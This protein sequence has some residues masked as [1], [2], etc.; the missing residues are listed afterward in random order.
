[1]QADSAAVAATIH[2]IRTVIEGVVEAQG[3]IA[4]AVTEQ[5]AASEEAQRAITGAA[6][7]ADQMARD[8]RGVAA[9]A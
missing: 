8:L 6:D 4:S 3:T 9:L 1:V 7:E 5:S 2:R